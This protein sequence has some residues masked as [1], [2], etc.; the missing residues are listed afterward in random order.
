[1]KKKKVLL[2]VI[3]FSLLL[4]SVMVNFFSHNLEAETLDLWDG[5]V[6]TSFSS[7]TGSSDDPYVISTGSEL[8]Y[9]ASQVNNQVN[10]ANTYFI[11]NNDIDLY[12]NAWTVIGNRFENSND[13]YFAGHFNG[14]NRTIYRLYV[15]FE[16]STYT[17]ITLSGL[18]GYVLGSSTNRATIE[19]LKLENVNIE[20]L[21]SGRGSNN[22][23]GAIVGVSNYC[24]IKN[25]TV[26]NS[27][28][29]NDNSELLYKISLGVDRL[30]YAGGI[31]GYGSNTNISYTSSNAF[32]INEATNIS[33]L[34]YIGGI[35]GFS[36]NENSISNSSFSSNIEFNKTHPTRLTSSSQY[37]GGLVGF[38]QGSLTIENCYA[39][40]D[41][42][43]NF[44][45]CSLGGLV[46]TSSVSPTISKC[47]YSGQISQNSSS[48]ANTSSICNSRETNP[49]SS[50]YS[51]I[52]YLY[53]DGISYSE[54]TN[55]EKIDESQLADKST[56]K[57]FD[58]DLIWYMDKVNNM[59]MLRSIDELPSY[60]IVYSDEANSY[61]YCYNIED[62]LN[63]ISTSNYDMTLYLMQNVNI[64]SDI[65]IKPK[66]DIKLSFTSITNTF[67]MDLNTS[68]VKFSG[69][70]T[71]NN[72]IFKNS[73]TTVSYGII[74]DGNLS[75]INTK[76]INEKTDFAIYN[77]SGK[78]LVI[79]NC[80]INCNG[81]LLVNQIGGKVD[82]NS[83]II[84]LKENIFL[85]YENSEISLNG[86]ENEKNI[87]NVENTANDNY[88]LKNEGLGLLKISSQTEINSLVDLNIY[89][90]AISTN[91][92]N[93]QIECL[94]DYNSLS[95]NISIDKGLL[96]DDD[97]YVAKN[98]SSG[99]NFSINSVTEGVYAIK[100]G[101]YYIVTK[102]L[103]AYLY[104]DWK[105]LLPCSLDK[106]AKIE[107]I[108]SDDSYKNL[109]KV[110]I[111]ATSDFTTI[112]SEYDISED[113]ICYYEIN[114]SGNYELKIYSKATIICPTDS[115]SLFS[116]FSNLTSLL[117]LNL[118]FENVEI[119]DNM[120]ENLSSLVELDLSNI[121]F[122]SLSSANNVFLNS[123][124]LYEIT[125]PTILIDEQIALNNNLRF[126]EYNS[127]NVQNKVTINNINRENS[128]KVIKVCFELTVEANG[129]KFLQDS[130]LYE[131]NGQ[132]AKCLFFY[133][134][135]V[136]NLPVATK[137]GYQIDK[138]QD[139]SAQEFLINN[140]IEKDLLVTIIWKEREDVEY[141]AETY[142]QNLDDLSQYTLSETKSYLGVTNREITLDTETDSQNNEYVVLQ[143]TSNKI[144]V[145]NGFTFSDSEFYNGQTK[146]NTAIINPNENQKLVI[147]IYLNRKS[148]NLN[149]KVTTSANGGGTNGG[150]IAF[151]S[152]YNLNSTTA[153]FGQT[154]KLYILENVGYELKSLIAKY[155]DSSSIN[156]LKSDKNTEIVVDKNIEIEG[157][158]EL[159]K[160]LVVLTPSDE[161][162]IKFVDAIG[163]DL[164]LTNNLQQEIY[165]N[166]SVYVK[167]VANAGYKFKYFILSNNQQYSNNPLTINNIT[168]QMQVSVET[169]KIHSLVANFN[170]QNGEIKLN[171]NSLVSGQVLTDIETQSQ[172]ELVFI[173]K[174]EHIFCNYVKINNKNADLIDVDNSN[175]KK[176]II[177]IDDDLVLDV[178]FDVEKFAVEFI[179]NI[180]NV[181]NNKII[182]LATN[183]VTTKQSFS[184]G[185]N[186]KFVVEDVEIGYRVKSWKINNEIKLNLDETTFT[187]NEI[188]LL[189]D[190]KLSVYVEFEILVTIEQNENGKVLVNNN[191]TSFYA[192]LNDELNVQIISNRGY[193]IDEFLYDIDSLEI[194]DNFVVTLTKTIKIGSTF[195]SKVLTVTLN[196][197]KNNCDVNLT[198]RDSEYVIGSILHF[199]VEMKQG[200]LF[201][202][203][204]LSYTNSK[205]QG[206]FNKILLEQDYVVTV[207][208]V[209]NDELIIKVNTEIIKYV[210]TINVKGKGQVSNTKLIDNQ[211]SFTYFESEELL[212]MPDLTYKIKSVTVLSDDEDVEDITNSV[213]NSKIT[214]PQKDCVINVEFAPIT[215][216]DDDIRAKS[217]AGGNG[218]AT[219][220]YLISSP[221]QL[222]LMSY[223]INNGEYNLLT[224]EYYSSCHY[225]LTQDIS[226]MGNY[227]VPIGI[228]NN[229]LQKYMFTGVF[230]YQFH[231]INHSVVEDE[232]IITIENNVFGVCHDAKFINKE[233]VNYML[234]MGI[235]LSI[236]FLIL[237]IIAIIIKKK[238]SK[239]PKRVI[240]MPGSNS[241][242]ETNGKNETNNIISRPNFDDF[243]KNNKK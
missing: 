140:V 116:D 68:S 207:D 35:I 197:D 151:D 173:P 33:N 23:V 29:L 10:Y 240:I 96:G 221:N 6:A 167:F 169:I 216:L 230:D 206:I 80:E 177:T 19:N 152:N 71:V 160:V 22:Y 130:D 88:L 162:T 66:T 69:N 107:F 117:L 75:L 148:Y 18:F 129:G 14:N 209:S 118:N 114:S 48:S 52:Y 137:T 46:G 90:L 15:P 125:L 55:V 229:N 164:V 63:Y 138:Y 174:N 104:K 79:S 67:T 143:N 87:I 5:S 57:N 195:K 219:D 58:F 53:D 155:D 12:G 205:Y 61:N 36:Y 72:V 184:Y 142:Y 65:E 161:G 168:S 50:V 172:L 127:E 100:T 238:M 153:L 103:K 91:K 86:N 210:I 111:G 176:L 232:S 49:S 30:T 202:D 178:E 34:I 97:Y 64:S 190:K 2:F 62:T 110:Y 109:Q 212:I 218:S 20:L 241:K 4:S 25:C 17:G 74:N 112:K 56:F 243:F 175:N 198:S 8:A 131:Y 28:D 42:S 135:V 215:W 101:E 120:F 99:D 105:N 47:Y 51:D 133:D 45:N 92:N 102:N 204:D 1:M 26:S 38:S 146:S 147:K 214:L 171:N 224:N 236:L 220:P 37:G 95:L 165:Y 183:L 235:G 201:K 199:K 82:I 77:N 27:S 94:D 196:Y 186:L 21:S 89:L 31:V 44:T 85:N 9:L 166:Q 128:N 16:D 59:P 121:T 200:Y 154:V 179:S 170:E 187:G 41:L 83:S 81:S 193:K 150:K 108:S 242:L 40:G 208:D 223:L 124:K 159:T 225:R 231:R 70:I 185:E 126:S 24:D 134:E 189:V 157:M 239:K 73:D 227:W 211:I 60:K 226:L 233:R 76:I 213:K 122:A 228:N 78:N 194:K 181:S 145:Q 188:E 180:N 217:F 222:A 158:F 93:Y 115:T 237:F 84:N 3:V 163:N 191:D 39:T 123:D 119:I 132:N 11:L 156:L 54:F 234:F 13:C 32:L 98:A 106:I 149:I 136:S 139:E 182:D 7:G 203:I 192:D 144:L 141:I 43:N 113:V